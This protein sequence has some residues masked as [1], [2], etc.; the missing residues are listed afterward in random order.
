MRTMTRYLLAFLLCFAALEASHAQAVEVKIQNDTDFRMQ[1]LYLFADP[2]GTRGENLLGDGSLF[3][4]GEATVAA[5][6]DDRYLLAVDSEG[7]RYLVR[8]F[9]PAEDRML[10]LSLDDLYFGEELGATVASGV[11]E[12]RVVNDTNYRF[13]DLWY[14]AS[15]QGEWNRVEVDGGIE[16]GGLVSV[17]VP[18][19][20]GVE[21][22][23]MRG[24][25]ED[26]DTYSKG[27]I[28]IRDRRSVRFTFDDLQW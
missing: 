16:P 1:E 22:L 10:S 15:G 4:G 5:A 3:P 13:T 12:L 23:E 20:D 17:L 25:D 7:D 21:T 24:E 26:G 28:R 27:G 19:S 8:G 18:V 6:R 11:W 9:N 2:A 14:R